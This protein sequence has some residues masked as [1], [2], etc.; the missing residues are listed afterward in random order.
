MGGFRDEWRQHDEAR[1]L[2]IGG[3]YGDAI[4]CEIR[5][6]PR[7]APGPERARRA[8]LLLAVVKTPRRVPAKATV[9]SSSWGSRH[10]S[11]SATWSANSF[12]LAAQLAGSVHTQWIGLGV[13]VHRGMTRTGCHSLTQVGGRGHWQKET[14]RGHFCGCLQ[15]RSARRACRHRPW[16]L[17]RSLRRAT[18]PIIGVVLATWTSCC[19]MSRRGCWHA[20][21][22]GSRVQPTTAGGLRRSFLLAI[23]L[24]FDERAVRKARSDAF[25]NEIG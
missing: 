13:A 23:K 20:R 18:A 3:S 21:P 1:E 7:R 6:P 9:D 14:G 4:L 24:E 2:P 11:A 15:R 25:A 8:G 5:G 10:R 19:A 16:T 17:T 12:G 22:R